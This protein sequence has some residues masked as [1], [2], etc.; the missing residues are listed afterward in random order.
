M[1]TLPVLPVLIPMVFAVLSLLAPSYRRLIGLIGSASL[2]LVAALLVLEVH[3]HGIRVVHLGSWPAPFG[4][5]F[6]A[7][8]FSTLMVMMA[9]TIA[10][11]VGIYAWFGIDTARHRY[12]FYTFF[13]FLLAGVCG[14]F[15]TGDLFNMYVFFEVLLISSFVLL[16]LGGERPQLEGAVK[17]VTLN[18]ISSTFFLIALAL[19]YG[20]LGTLNMADLAVK[21]GILRED[22]LLQA[23]ALLLLAAFGVKAAI[24]PLYFWLPASYHTPPA[25]VSAVFAGLMTKVGVYALIR[26][27]T[28]IFPENSGPSA[29]VFLL[30]ACLTMFFGVIGAAVQFDFRRILAF[31]SISQIGYMVMGL[32]LYTPL[33]LAG[34]LFFIVHHTLVKSNLFLV[35]GVVAHLRG[36]FHLKHLGGLYRSQPWLAVLFVLAAFSLAGLPPLTGFWAKFMLIKSGLQERAYG[37]VIVALVVSLLTLFSMTKIWARYSGKRTRIRKRLRTPTGRADRAG[38]FYTLAD[39]GIQFCG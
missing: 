33:G 3:G 19:L 6:V 37:T 15:L 2:F 27:F 39:S 31:H 4:I 5:I 34:T 1:R 30:L 24:F 32:G 22:A 11:A 10:L 25:A 20:K 17:Y 12:G 21:A 7:D 14:A 28:L 35:S 9:G 8:E 13:F 26:V 38:G 16:A 18:L 36:T 29:N 23:A